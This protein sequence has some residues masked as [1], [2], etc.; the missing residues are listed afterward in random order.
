MKEISKSQTKHKI[1]LTLDRV[2]KALEMLD[3][4][5][6][7]LPPVIHVAGTNGKGSTIAFL[8]AIFEA[9][10]YKCHVYTS[11]HLIKFN[12]RIV[13][14]GNE[15]TDDY[16]ASLIEEV[17]IKCK[18][19]NLTFFETTTLVGFLAFARNKADVLLLETGMGGQFDATNIIEKPALTIITPISYDHQEFLGDTIEKIA[20]EKACIMKKATKCIISK[21]TDAAKKVLF[22][23][24]KKIGADVIEFESLSSL[25]G[26]YNEAIH[27]NDL[28]S[29]PDGLLR[30]A[31]NDDYIKD[32]KFKL[33]LNGSHQYIN[34]ACAVTA[35]KNL[36]KFSI[37]KE[38]I[39]KGLSSAK[40]PARLQKI[41]DNTYLD[42]AHNLDGARI[43]A[44]FIKGQRGGK[45]V[46]VILGMLKNKDIYALLNELK[47]QTDLLMAVNI[48]GENCFTAEEIVE[49]ADKLSIK[50]IPSNNAVK[51]LESA[52][53][54]Y[55]D[56]LII[57][58]GSLYLAGEFLP[59][60]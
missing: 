49:I 37:T 56:S 4:P 42:G 14:S 5:Q 12:E 21:Q 51:T 46:V 45:K 36:P 38:N 26:A 27:S 57:I 32:T 54:T 22:D 8:R 40:W 3:N 10:N 33:S 59:R 6:Y 2:F 48:A 53:K 24:A 35:I 47:P 13:I 28:D 60:D 55:P 23:Y 9:A 18:S 16:L 19:L 25:Q 39:G 52:R 1:D 58:C 34:A 30:F 11:P 31:R 43:V 50:A 29:K 41:A 17:S 15:I 44:D 7:K 20:Y